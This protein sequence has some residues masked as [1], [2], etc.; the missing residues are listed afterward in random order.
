MLTVY[1]ARHGL[2]TMSSNNL[3]CGWSDPELTEDGRQMA[4]ALGDVYSTLSWTAIYASPFRRTMATA[5]PLAKRAKLSVHAEPGFREISY[6]EWEGRTFE[7]AAKRWP[8][9]YRKWRD[10]PGRHHP[11]GGESAE[12]V[13]TRAIA[14]LDAI[15]AEHADGNVMV[16]S[17][18]ATIRIVLCS[19]L[20]IDIGLFRSRLD[21]PISSVS[22][23]EF[24]PE[25]P[26][27][28]LIGDISH[29]PEKLRALTRI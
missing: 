19:L 15:C 9:E 8:A 21:A 5:T 6:G 1:L 3:Y 22:A 2:T 10:D 17:H 14:A 29:L 13:A 27:V 4:I 25:G 12:M 23:V 11:P 28:R 7:E 16:V 26:M 24:R 18:K 20:G